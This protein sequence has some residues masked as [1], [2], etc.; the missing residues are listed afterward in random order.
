MDTKIYFTKMNVNKWLWFGLFP[1]GPVFLVMGFLFRDLTDKDFRLVEII[2]GFLASICVIL[3]WL[4]V[5][6]KIFRRYVSVQKRGLIIKNHV[7]LGPVSISWKDIEQ[8]DF[9]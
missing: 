6:R 9:P 3:Y 5:E 8:I 1:I 7:L 2:F 4:A